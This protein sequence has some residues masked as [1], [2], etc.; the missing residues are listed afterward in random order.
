[1]RAHSWIDFTENLPDA[2]V[3]AVLVDTASST[4]YVG[5]DVVSSPAARPAQPQSKTGLA[6]LLAKTPTSVPT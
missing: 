6:V 2:P 5:T 4:V 1:M 3:N